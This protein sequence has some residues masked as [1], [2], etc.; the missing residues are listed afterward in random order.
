MNRQ[1]HPK[2]SAPP[3]S[4]I[5]L[6]DDALSVVGA[7]QAK[8]LFALLDETHRCLLAAR[9]RQ[10]DRLAIDALRRA[11]HRLAETAGYLGFVAGQDY[12]YALESLTSR[13]LVN[14][15]PSASEWR[16]AFAME[17]HALGLLGPRRIGA[18]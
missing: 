10:D 11:G 7:Q 12:A 14:A 13:L 2:P 15:R 6:I 5:D 9:P 18:P 1:S 17:E 16:R 4:I 8:K 3:A